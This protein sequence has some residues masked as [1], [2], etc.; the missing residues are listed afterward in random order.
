MSGP[1]AGLRVVDLTTVIAGP[2]ATQ[3]LG[4]MGADVVKIEPPAGDIMR[5]PGPARTPGMGAAFLNC[6][7][8][9]DSLRLDLKQPADL[10]R[11]VDLIAGADVFIHN[12]RM[13][14]ARRLGL[15]PDALS[16]RFPR[17]V[18][19]AITGFGQDGPY[20][21]RPAYDDI[22]QAASGWAALENPPRYAPTIV[23]DKTAGLHAVAAINAALLHRER[24]GQGQA[25]EVP[26]FEV[27]V[28]FLAVEHL[29]WQTFDPPAGPCGYD[30][31]LTPWR[32]PYLAADGY[33][34]VMPYTSA[35]WRAFFTAAGRP[36]WAAD[37][38]LT[39]DRARAAGIATLY[40]RLADCLTARGVAEWLRMLDA[41]EIPCSPV[42]RLDDLTDDPH[43]QTV[44]LFQPLTHPTEGAMRAVRPPIR[45]ARTPC[46]IRKPAPR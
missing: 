2:Y 26:M 16:A 19:C 44:G 24:S 32:R 31:V 18:H 34:A 37:P 11:L 10:A 30:R 15:D 6:N 35:H 46:D 39:D 38:V 4:D 7:R 43:V 25:I 13:K 28:S 40:E 21:D 41:L 33:I 12:M 29:A 8:N 36:D 22:I 14:A 42:N 5:A 1:L 27:M 17:L 9:K 20:R 3:M 23:A 45:F